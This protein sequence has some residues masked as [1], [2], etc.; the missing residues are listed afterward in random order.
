MTELDPA[1]WLCQQLAKALRRH[2]VEIV[3]QVFGGATGEAERRERLRQII[4][5]HKL[6]GV[7]C[8]KRNG[9][10]E[11]YSEFYERTFKQP[12]ISPQ[13]LRQSA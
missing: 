10:P 5:E 9:K 3:G 1:M 4:T 11:T 7:A 2:P 12:L 13:T 8:G 6:G